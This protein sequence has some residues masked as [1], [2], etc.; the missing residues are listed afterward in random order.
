MVNSSRFGPETLVSTI[1][2]VESDSSSGEM[3][4]PHFGHGNAPSPSI[5]VRSIVNS[6]FFL[7]AFF[8]ILW[9][10]LIFLSSFGLNDINFYESVIHF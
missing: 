2:Y 4:V 6:T 8:I 1:S 9:H 5:L 3:R 10:L 7:T